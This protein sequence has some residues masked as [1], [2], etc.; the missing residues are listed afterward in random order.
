MD[1]LLAIII[2]SFGIKHAVFRMDTLEFPVLELV[3]PWE[4]HQLPQ[5]TEELK[6]HLKH[7]KE[8][9]PF[10]Q[11]IYSSSE[12]R[13]NMLDTCVR[14]IVPSAELDQFLGTLNSRDTFPSAA[15]LI[16]TELTEGQNPVLGNEFFEVDDAEEHKGWVNETSGQWENSEETLRKSHFAFR[17]KERF[18]RGWNQSKWQLFA[19][20]DN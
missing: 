5:K 20:F 9:V 19:Y 1:E 2:Q 3:L 18:L 8:S 7:I 11:L 14:E 13:S 12:A 16:L 17:T 6:A 4:Q 15:W 10:Q